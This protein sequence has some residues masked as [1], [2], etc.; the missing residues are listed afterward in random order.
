MALLWSHGDK[1]DLVGSRDSLLQETHCSLHRTVD[2]TEFIQQFED[3]LEELP[4]IRRQ[5][6][7]RGSCVA[8]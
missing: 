6:P 1:Y 3:L 7:G 8:T 2:N 5:Q 4:G